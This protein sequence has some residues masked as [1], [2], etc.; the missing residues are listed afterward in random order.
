MIEDTKHDILLNGTGSQIGDSRQSQFP[1]CH[2]FL[3]ASPC[4]IEVPITRK[5]M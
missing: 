3:E 1:T 4:H 5:N 2:H